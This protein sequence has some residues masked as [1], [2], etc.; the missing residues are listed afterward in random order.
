LD[1]VVAREAIRVTMA[2]YN[3]NGDSARLAALA[4]CFTEDGV[5]EFVGRRLVGRAE[6]AKGLEVPGEFSPDL[7]LMRHN[8]TTSLIELDGDRATGRS[9]FQVVTNVGLDHG[10]VY[11]DTFA[12]VDGQWL[13]A[14]RNVRIEWQA[15]NSLCGPIPLGRR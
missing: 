2:R 10:G 1:D 6:I 7:T 8:L 12:R 4:D 14:Y 3:I 5:L 13:I 15:A 9:Y 11:T